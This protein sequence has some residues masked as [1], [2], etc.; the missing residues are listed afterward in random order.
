MP[1][2]ESPLPSAGG[3]QVQVQRCNWVV[4]SLSSFGVGLQNNGLKKCPL[5]LQSFARTWVQS[6]TNC[7]GI[8]QE[9]VAALLLL[10]RARSV[11]RAGVAVAAA[12]ESVDIKS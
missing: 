7:P 8:V 6:P 5:R 2:P 11:V 12:T 3:L 1:R 10:D 4:A 9:D